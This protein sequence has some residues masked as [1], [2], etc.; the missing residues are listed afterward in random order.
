ML[1]C[2]CVAC[3]TR[4]N[5]VKDIRDRIFNEF[6]LKRRISSSLSEKSYIQIKSEFERYLR[7]HQI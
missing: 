3:H 7:S 1:N 5:A 6:W 2:P 4:D